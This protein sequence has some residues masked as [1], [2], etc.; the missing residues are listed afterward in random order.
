MHARLRTR[1]VLLR[2]L[3]LGVLTL[4]V[5]WIPVTGEAEAAGPSPRLDR[6]ERAIL[7]VLNR[8]RAAHGLPRL[9][10][11]RRLQRAADAHCKDMLRANFFAH[12]SSNGT[13]MATRVRRYRRSNRIGETLAYIPTRGLHQQAR[14]VVRMWMNSPSHR[15]AILSPSFRRV[16]IA[17]RI[18]RLGS[19]RAA[20]YTANFA[21]TR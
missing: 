20:V 1:H 16:G 2:T 9:R 19:V 14:K 4:V 7:K 6:A 10:A 18:G 21:S 11:N 12:T 5:S 15:A 13:P 17:R 8:T 3:A